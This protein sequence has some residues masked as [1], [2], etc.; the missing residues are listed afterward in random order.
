MRSRLKR[1]KHGPEIVRR[2]LFIEGYSFPP[3]LKERLREEYE[4]Q[5]SGS[6]LSMVLEGLRCWFLACL[7][8]D[9]KVLGM[10]S[11]G[12]DGAWHEF[13]LL[14]REY[15]AFC[16]DAFG[17]YLHH[18]PEVTMRAPLGDAMARTLAVLDRHSE[19]AAPTASGIPLLF[20]VDSELGLDD[21]VEWT[22]EDLERL[23][24]GG[25]AVGGGAGCGGDGQPD[26]GGASCGASCGGGGG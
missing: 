7:Q 21:G 18:A 16:D 6:Q 14:T 1:E 13:I 5:L 9:G 24:A 23:R 11:K 2:R 12:V 15:H 17:H 19:A 4:P 20:A 8:A 26:G 25:S 10:P 22:K 3:A